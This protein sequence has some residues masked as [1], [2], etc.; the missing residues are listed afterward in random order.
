MSDIPWQK[1]GDTVDR[2]VGAMRELIA[3]INLWVNALH[4]RPAALLEPRRIYYLPK[5][6]PESDLAL[7]R[8]IDELYLEYLFVGSTSI[9]CASHLLGCHFIYRYKTVKK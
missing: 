9:F 2:I 8:R 5:L 1:I 3:Q 4:P 6:V 7:M